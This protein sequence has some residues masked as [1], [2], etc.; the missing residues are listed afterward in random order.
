MVWRMFGNLDRLRSEMNHLFRSEMW[1]R[2]QVR[3]RLVPPVNIYE[4]PEEFIVVFEI[5]GADKEKFDITLTA[6]NLH[7]S[8]AFRE[9][10]EAGEVQR[11]ERPRGSFKRTVALSADV[12]P[13]KV[14]AGYK[15]GV[16]TVRVAKAE[17]A[18]PKRIE[19]NVES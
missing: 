11:E 18:R 1:P 8:G 6:G 3:E 14:E 2:Y 4:S 9:Y 19:V 7:L 13:A 10:G 12:D 16:L 15:D 5:P 17:A